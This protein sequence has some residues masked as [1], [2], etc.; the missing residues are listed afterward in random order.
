MN[1]KVGLTVL[2][3]R[4][5]FVV[6][7]GRRLN[8]SQ[9]IIRRHLEPGTGVNQERVH[10]S[11]LWVARLQLLQRESQVQDV[12]VD[13][14]RFP[15]FGVLGVG[16][17]SDGLA[18][19]Q[20]GKSVCLISSRS[21]VVSRREVLINYAQAGVLNRTRPYPRERGA[22]HHFFSSYSMV[23]A[24]RNG[25]AA[26]PAEMKSKEAIFA[27]GRGLSQVVT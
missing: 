11:G 24:T 19:W 23:M 10:R 21:P 7:P 6:E 26:C 17:P 8:P 22:Y 25:E 1:A 27:S 13:G 20:V 2:A 9:L 3:T 16:R 12:G 14:A 18:Q 15:H 4:D 5:F